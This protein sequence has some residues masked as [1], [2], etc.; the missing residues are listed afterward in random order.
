MLQLIIPDRTFS[1]EENRMLQKKPSFSLG[2]LISGEFTSEYENY[3]GDQFPFREFWVSTKSACELIL[4]K[5]DNNNVYFGKE[6]YLLQKPSNPDT[7]LFDKNILAINQFAQA[8]S[9]IPVY[10]LLAPNSVHVLTDKL[11]P[12]ATAIDA[13]MIMEKT[14]NRV[15]PIVRLIDVCKPLTEHK[16]EYIYYKTD[17]HW[18]TTGAYYAYKEAGK[19]MGFATLDTNDFTIEQVSDNFYGTLY[20][21]S[22]Q[23]F[24]SPDSIHLFKPKTEVKYKVEYVDKG[25]ITRN[26]YESKYL[27]KKDQYSIFLDGNHS[28][29]KITTKAETDRKL[30]VIKDSY[31]NSFIPFL[32][33]NFAEIH[34]MDMRYYNADVLQ[35]VEQNEFSDILFL[36]NTIT[37]SEDKSLNKIVLY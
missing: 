9:P 25:I 3:I 27:Q 4:Q 29:I 32:I 2:K 35:Y 10:F 11:P 26:M 33:N 18:T 20:S 12:F 21:K 8:V 16:Q 28:L 24:V 34:L 14:N 19:A 5:K 13:S 22:G 23:H 15:S 31:A 36:Y 1:E 37:F 17:H 7:G 30:L 6:S